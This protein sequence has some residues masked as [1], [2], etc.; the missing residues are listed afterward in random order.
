MFL[1]QR[2]QVCHISNFLQ[3]N[4]QTITD[5]VQSVVIQDIGNNTAKQ[6]RGA[7][8]ARQKHMQQEHAEDMQTS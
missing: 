6:R 7:N 3:G 5:F 2:N 4:L 1:I 8:S